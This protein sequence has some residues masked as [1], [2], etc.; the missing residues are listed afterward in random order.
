MCMDA[1]I[2]SFAVA[3]AVVGF[4]IIVVVA[5]GAVFIDKK[6]IRAVNRT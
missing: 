1:I 3:E 4:G 2:E 5:L 6:E